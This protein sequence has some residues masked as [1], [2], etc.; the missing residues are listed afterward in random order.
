MPAAAQK[1]VATPPGPNK[2]NVSAPVA[3][4]LS[5]TASDGSGLELVSLSAQ[6][7]I[8]DPLAFTELHLTFRNPESRV[9]EGRFRITLPPGATISRFAMRIGDRWQEGEIVEQQAARIAYEDFLHRRQDPALLETEA[10]NEFSARVF[11]I[12]PH[13]TKELIVSYAQELTRTGESYRLPLYGLPKLG[14]LTIRALVGKAKTT[15]G[16]ASSLGGQ[17]AQHEVVEVSKRDF[18]PDRDFEVAPGG[19]AGRLGLRHDNLVVARVVPLAE[20]ARVDAVSSLFVLIDSS[21]SRALGLGDLI[22]A[23]EGLMAALRKTG[24]PMVSVAAFDQD[25]APIFMGRAS[26]MGDR[27]RR[28]LTER[29]ALGAS[30]LDHAL[31]WLAGAAKKDQRARVL[32][33]TDGVVTAGDVAA[34]KLR[35]RVKAL[36]PAGVER[37]DVLAVGGIRD[38]VLLGRLVTAGLA[39][40]GVVLDG[41]RLSSP[42]VSARRLTRA[43][44]SGVKVAVDGAGWVWPAVLNGVQPGDEVLVYADLPRDRPFHLKIDGVPLNVAG[45]LVSVPGPLLERAWVRARIARV[46]EQRDNAAA[47]DRDLAEALKKQAIDLSVKYRVLCPFTSLLVLETEQ[48]YA[49]FG[50]ERRSL[51]DIL[52]I[53]AGGIALVHRTNVAAPS[54]QQDWQQEWPKQDD[55]NVPAT[56]RPL[57]KDRAGL[58]GT[59]NKRHVM[60]HVASGSAQSTAASRTPAKGSLDDLLEGSL[61]GSKLGAQRMLAPPPAPTPPPPRVASESQPRAT[62]AANNAFAADTAVPADSGIAGLS[63]V[64]AAGASGAVEGQLKE[65]LS[66]IHRGQAKQAL[67]KALAWRQRDAGDVLALVALGECWEALGDGTQAARAYGSI[68]DLF[69][70]RADMRRFAGEH[71]E[72]IRSAGALALAV[73]TYRKTVE[74]RPDHPASHRLLGFALLKQGHPRQAFDALAAGIAQS[75]PRDRFRGVDRILREDL[76]LA[77]A[78]WMKAEPSHANDVRD[79]L[80]RAGGTPETAPSLRFILNWETDA[81]DVDFHIRDGKGG[82]AF[83]SAP[84]LPSG[85][86]LYA[87]VTTGYGPECFTIRGPAAARAA[88]PYRLQAHY[89]SRGPMGYGMGKLQVIDHDGRGGLRFEE[90]PFVIMQD[91]AYVDLGVVAGTI[92]GNVAAIVK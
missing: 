24:D 88:A 18:K 15:T 35:A 92:G 40:D 22:A 83:Y 48:D 29:R 65:I 38:D 75:Y 9:R 82:H 30:D 69:P 5:L 4:L 19:A 26:A 50:I 73:D 51:A 62:A 84:R 78:A 57:A 77:A 13:A 81:N 34:D 28:K 17:R 52:T 47:S 11:P 45:G 14:T 31:G 91:G 7:V 64:R 85:G 21:E 59:R 76:G 39:R 16:A 37:L 23:F 86:E 20:G 25:V 87:D 66:L 74:Q 63:A 61:T 3:A 56:A 32:L 90:R 41:T 79:R 6:A 36:G 60:E 89:Y 12:P 8:E 49:R 1:L 70:G 72:R 71:L 46:I 68:I 44:R 2:G 53:G 67:T 55:S 58:D 54:E 10:G 33:V 42:E 43:T 27:V 80:N